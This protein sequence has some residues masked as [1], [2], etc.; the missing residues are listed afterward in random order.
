MA[1]T[2]T[3]QDCSA[4][5][6][7]RQHCE[8]AVAA[9]EAVLAEKPRQRLQ[10]VDFGECAIVRLRDC[11][12]ERLRQGEQAGLAQQLQD[13]L[14]QVNIA[15]SLVVGVEYPGAGIQQRSLEQAREVLIELEF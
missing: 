10:I 13:A 11:L 5:G 3:I 4:E 15:L 8:E 7:L 14:D 6:V 2:R 12:I 1:E 9:I